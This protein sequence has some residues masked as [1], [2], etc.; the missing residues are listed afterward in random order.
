MQITFDFQDEDDLDG[1]V[2]VDGLA[3]V[4]AFVIALEL[5]DDER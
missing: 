1:S 5:F 4:G 2:P 3:D